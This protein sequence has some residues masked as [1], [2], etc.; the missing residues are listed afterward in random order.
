MAI[1][2]AGGREHGVREGREGNK[3]WVSGEFLAGEEW[4]ER[5]D[6]RF[7]P[8]L[9]RWLHEPANLGKFREMFG[10]D[11]DLRAG[12]ETGERGARKTVCCVAIRNFLWVLWTAVFTWMVWVRAIP[13]FRTP[14]WAG[15][16]LH[17]RGG[18]NFGGLSCGAG[19]SRVCFKILS[20]WIVRLVTRKHIS[21]FKKLWNY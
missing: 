13:F 11:R 16:R 6:L 9:A 21:K 5:T 15:G 10:G 12:R 1:C 4:R 19:T 3:I 14:K 8:L 20:A 18:S 17:A 7:L 2:N